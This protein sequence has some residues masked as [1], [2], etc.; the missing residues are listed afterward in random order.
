MNIPIWQYAVSMISYIAI[1]L[2]I[3]EVM[4]KHPKFAAIFWLASLFTFPLWAN[5]LEGWF[6]WAKTFSVLVPTALVVGFARLAYLNQ[7]SGFWKFFRRDWVLWTLYGVLMLNILEASFKD[8]ALGNYFNAISGFILCATMPLFRP[9]AKGKR[10]GWL[11]TTKQP[12][13]LLVY[14]SASWNFLYTIWNIAFVYA[15]NPGF[16]ASSFSILLAAELYPI[17]KRR[18]ELYV[19]S[20]VYTL[21]IHILIR[22]TYDIFTPVMDSSQFANEKIVYY[23]GIINFALHVPYLFWFYY[24]EY[25]YKKSQKVS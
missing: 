15:E 21:A 6:R 1:L 10:R 13:D 16:A 20:R 17:I 2:L 9:K 19:I 18:P 8:L 14:T 3:I 25:K 23:W 11:F 4:R 12:G 22:S 5:E 7:K 24:K